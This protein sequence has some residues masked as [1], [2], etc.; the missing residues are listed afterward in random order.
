MYVIG[1]ERRSRRGGMIRCLFARE[2]VAERCVWWWRS[3]ASA[4]MSVLAYEYAPDQ[5]GE[6]WNNGSV[7]GEGINTGRFAI[8]GV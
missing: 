4:A 6:R 3:E 2:K 1:G 7:D 5:H 8:D